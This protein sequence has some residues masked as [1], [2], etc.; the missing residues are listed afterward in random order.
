M[1][2]SNKSTKVPKLVRT[3]MKE[4]GPMETPKTREDNH[5]DTWRQ[6]NKGRQPHGPME[7]AKQ[8][9]TTKGTHGDGNTRAD[10]QRDSERHRNKGRQPQ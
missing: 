2:R 4:Q 7:T 1:K 3:V 9:Q 5:M 10:N 8:G 6:Q